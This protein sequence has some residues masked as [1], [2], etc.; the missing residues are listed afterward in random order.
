MIR[1]ADRADAEWY[2]GNTGTSLLGPVCSAYHSATRLFCLR[3]VVC[4]RIVKTEGTEMSI[5][6]AARSFA[7]GASLLYYCAQ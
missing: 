6:I 3:I 2:V 4:C 1:K 5:V 7:S